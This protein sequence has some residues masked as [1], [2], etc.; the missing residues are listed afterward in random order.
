MWMVD[1]NGVREAVDAIKS[2]LADAD[3]TAQGMADLQGIIATKEAHLWRASVHC[4]Y[5]RVVELGSLLEMELKFLYGA[6]EAIEQGNSGRAMGLLDD[7]LDFVD[8]NYTDETP[9]SFV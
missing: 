8:E 1:K 3:D 4:S 6:A 2:K 5:A 7:F 9:P